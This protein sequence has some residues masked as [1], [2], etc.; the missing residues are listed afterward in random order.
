MA[1]RP[2]LGEVAGRPEHDDA[3]DGQGAEETRAG[4][5]VGWPVSAVCAVAVLCVVASLLLLM[6]LFGVRLS[7]SY[8]PAIGGSMAEWFEALAT[9]IA[10]PLAVLVGVRQLQSTSEQIELGR[11]QLLAAEQERIERSRAEHIRLMEAVDLRTCVANVLDR[12][13]LASQAERSDAERL[14]AEFRVRGWVPDTGNGAWE[15]QGERR[16]NAELLTTEPSSILPRPWF[17]AL[18]CTNR[19]AATV[20]LRRWT[21]VLDG[22]STDVESQTELRPGA[23]A[24]R[25]L[26]PDAGLKAAYPKSGDVESRLGELWAQVDATDATDRQFHI[27]AM[28]E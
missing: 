23:S 22:S 8:D 15:R 5:A 9:L 20:T 14:R 25:R 21:I 3:D 6:N 4:R 18:E 27:T 26:G 11:R 16:T 7:G 28:Q 17:A 10:V 13:D 19:G 12:P 2:T 24:R 1:D